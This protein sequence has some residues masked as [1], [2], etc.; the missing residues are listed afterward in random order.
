[1]FDLLTSF[2]QGDH[3]VDEWYNAVQA[4]INLARYPQET[5]RILHRD[6]FWFFLRD[7]EFVSKTIKDSKI[8]LNKFP[9]SKVRQLAKK[10]ESSKATGKYIQQ[11]ANEPQATQ[12]HLMRH[13]C[14]ELPPSKFQRK[15]KKS[16]KSGQITNKHYQEDK[17]RERMPQVHRRNYKNHQAYHASQEK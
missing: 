6:I 2:W 9:V 1:M 14:T 17:Q 12:I 15:Q 13:Q 10:M 16:I 4:Q 3:S 7:E 5:A 8:D 11:V